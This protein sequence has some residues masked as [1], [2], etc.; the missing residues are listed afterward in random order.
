MVLRLPQTPAL[1]PHTHLPNKHY[2]FS[3][4]GSDFYK[5]E[6]KLHAYRDTFHSLPANSLLQGR[7]P[8][9]LHVNLSIFSL[10]FVLT[11]MVVV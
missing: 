11:P 3:E 10:E 1:F 5:K 9:H 6:Y 7:I 8:F 4:H 2:E